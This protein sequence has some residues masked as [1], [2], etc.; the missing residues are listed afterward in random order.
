MNACIKVDRLTVR[1]SDRPVLDRLSFEV[2]EGTIFGLLGPSGAGK[3]TLIK[4]LTG[5]LRQ[6]EG[7][8]ELFGKDTRRLT[9]KDHMKIGAMLDNYGLY[10][11]L[12]VYENLSFYADIYHISHREIYDILKSIGL[13][14]A[15]KTTVSKLSKGMKSHYDRKTGLVFM[16]IMAVGIFISLLIGAVIGIA[17]RTQMMATSI[18]VP[19]MMIFSFLPMLSLFNSTVEKIARFVYSE[20]IS[21][22]LGHINSLELTAERIS[23]IGINIFIAMAV[24]VTIF[25]KCNQAFA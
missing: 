2:P 25:R 19:V 22:M 4:V 14:E 18:T 6:N 8:A 12:S 16:G 23:I 15:R 9:A 21:R 17:S 20:Q 11:R 7:K 5:Q 1:F 3:T 13:Y 10:E 24:F